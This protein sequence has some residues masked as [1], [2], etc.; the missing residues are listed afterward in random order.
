MLR[1]IL[2]SNREEVVIW[3]T[4]VI[5]IVMVMLPLGTLVYN[6]FAIS[7]VFG[8]LM[9]TTPF[10]V[11][12]NEDILQIGH[13]SARAPFSSFTKIL[14]VLQTLSLMLNLLFWT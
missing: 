12:L 6:S 11:L 10:Q 1:K 8:S 13:L 2:P 7:E 14:Q 4:I 5:V 9:K 3:M